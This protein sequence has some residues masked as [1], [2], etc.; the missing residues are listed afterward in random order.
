[1]QWQKKSE[2]RNRK[3][4]GNKMYVEHASKTPEERKKDKIIRKVRLVL[5]EES[6]K[7]R[8]TEDIASNWKAGLTYT[9]SGKRVGEIKDGQFEFEPEYMHLQDVFHKAMA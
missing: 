9:D 2:D 7:N 6:G 1:M 8:K 5:Y 4:K 3:Y